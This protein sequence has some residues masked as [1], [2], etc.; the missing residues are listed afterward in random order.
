MR[1]CERKMGFEIQVG[2]RDGDMRIPH[3]W[4]PERERCGETEGSWGKLGSHVP[5]HKMG[6]H[7]NFTADV[8]LLSI[9]YWLNV[10]WAGVAAQKML[11]MC[12][13][14]RWPVLEYSGRFMG[15][16]NLKAGGHMLSLLHATG[17]S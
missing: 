5:N 7:V 6:F 3:P 2:R 15:S 13:G 8:F 4:R 17:N 9:F 10:F 16:T 14:Q 1:E 12:E 11:G